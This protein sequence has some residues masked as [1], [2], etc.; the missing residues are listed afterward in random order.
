MNG[1]RNNFLSIDNCH[2]DIPGE[3]PSKR[4]SEGTTS[5]RGWRLKDQAEA[6]EGNLYHLACIEALQTLEVIGGWGE[7]MK[8]MYLSVGEQA[9][10]SCAPNSNF[11]KFGLE[12]AVQL[13]T[14]SVKG[15]ETDLANTMRYQCRPI[16]MHRFRLEL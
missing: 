10:R 3:R 5:R 6:E 8:C 12:T 11:S 7:I 14:P 9:L 15:S 13:V 4:T 1:I 16:G 2:L